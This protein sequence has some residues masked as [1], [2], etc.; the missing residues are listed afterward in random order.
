[1]LFRVLLAAG[2][3]ATVDVLEA[4]AGAVLLGAWANVRGMVA[5]ASAIVAIKFVFI[6][7]LPA[8]PSPAYSSILRWNARKHD[9]LRRLENPPN[10]G[11]PGLMFISLEN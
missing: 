4:P 11:L 6:F 8:G 3:A 2:L 1:M 9:S 7:S 10:S 5:T